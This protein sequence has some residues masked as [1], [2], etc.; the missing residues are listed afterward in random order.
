MANVLFTSY[1]NR[2]CLYCFARDKVDLGR[3]TGD[4]SMNLSLEGLEEIIRFYHRSQL[5]RFVILGGE[6]TLHPRFSQMVDRVL[7]E[8]AFKWV[9]VFSNGLMSGKALDY[10]AASTDPRLRVAINLNAPEEYS[11]EERDRVNTTMKRLGRKVGLGINIHSPDQDFDYLI[12]AFREFA[13]GG[14]IRLGIAHPIPGAGNVYA[15]DQDLPSI[16]SRIVDFA[17]KAHRN[18]F[19]FSF[20]CGFPFCMFTLD[21]H[22]ELLRFG[23]KFVSRC[24]PIIDIGPDLS[25]W[26]CFPLMNEVNRRLSDFETKNQAVDFYEGV[27][28]SFVPMGNRPECPQCR[29]RANHLCRGGCLARTLAAFR[30]PAGPL[31]TPGPR[32]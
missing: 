12:D 4:L 15:R 24:D 28:K 32:G 16:A 7:A 13:L 25:L 21:Q 3:D 6:P 1:C 23:V 31:G 27:H 8:C 17:E 22:R 20:D 29:Y 5:T 10:L 2:R 19:T 26:R 14:H 9:I 18:R 11:P 30:R